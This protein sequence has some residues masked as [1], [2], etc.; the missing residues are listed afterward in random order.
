MALDLRDTGCTKAAISKVQVLWKRDC[1]SPQDFFSPTSISTAMDNIS[2][3]M[4]V[5]SE[6]TRTKQED[7]AFLF[8]KTINGNESR[9][10]ATVF[11]EERKER[12]K[13]LRLQTSN[14]VVLTSEDALLGNVRE[15]EGNSEE[16]SAKASFRPNLSHHGIYDDHASSSSVRWRQSMFLIPHN[17]SKV[18]EEFIDANHV[19]LR[20]PPDEEKRILSRNIPTYRDPKGGGNDS[21]SSQ[22]LV[23]Q[24]APKRR[25]VEETYSVKRFKGATMSQI[26]GTNKSLSSRRL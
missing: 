20:D 2:Q 19:L 14:V 1:L 15:E 7:H 16:G 11:P 23:A 3:I 22:S 18:E 13:K 9:S 25:R 8:I 24:P 6:K 21:L 10:S 5:S 17:L 26:F 12:D 4:S